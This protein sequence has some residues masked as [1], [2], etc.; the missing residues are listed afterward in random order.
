MDGNDVLFLC[1]QGNL[2][3][4]VL[5]L[6]LLHLSELQ[7]ILWNK[8]VVCTS[9]FLPA[10][11][12]SANTSPITSTALETPLDSFQLCLLHTPHNSLLRA[13]LTLWLMVDF[14]S[15][16][17]IHSTVV[18]IHDILEATWL[19]PPSSGEQL[20]VLF[21]GTCA[22]LIT[23]YLEQVKLFFIANDVPEASTAIGVLKSHKDP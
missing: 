6:L 3:Y 23:N 11:S 13:R 17:R 19:C 16:D 12:T 5:P 8:S 7:N 15:T 20:A 21:S 22:R 1:S 4:A 9:T 14:A 18:I 10:G 2:C